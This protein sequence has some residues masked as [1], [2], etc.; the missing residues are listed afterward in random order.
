MAFGLLPTGFAPKTRQDI[1]AELLDDVEQGFGAPVDRSAGSTLTRLLEVYAD[2]LAEGWAAADQLWRAGDPGLA[3]AIALDDLVAAVGVR[4]LFATPSV[5]D[6]LCIGRVGTRLAAGVVVSADGV[7]F[8]SAADA[9]L[10]E[11]L[12]SARLE[13]K[14]VVP[15]TFYG[16]R[17]DGVGSGLTASAGQSAQR[18]ATALASLWTPAFPHLLFEARGDGVDL[19]ARA[20]DVVP[21]VTL[22][23]RPRQRLRVTLAQMSAGLTVTV[24]VWDS[25]GLVVRA[26]E[27][28]DNP[29][30]Y[31]TVIANLCGRLSGAALDARPGPDGRSID[32]V[33]NSVATSWTIGGWPGVSGVDRTPTDLATLTAKTV[34][35]AIVRFESVANGPIPALAGRLCRVETPL[36]GWD[37]VIN[38]DRAELGRDAETDAKLRGRLSRSRYIMASG[39]AGAIVARLRQDVPGLRGAAV[40]ENDGDA[41]DA[42]GRPAHSFE[43]VVD[44]NP[45]PATSLAIARVIEGLRPAGVAAVSTAVPA[46]RVTETWLDAH[47][48]E[49]TLVYSRPT[50]VPVTLEIAL[51]AHPDEVF[52]AGAEAALRDQVYSFGAAHGIGQ[53]V[54]IG[55]M[56]ALL[57]AFPGVGAID[58]L[59]ARRDASS[60]PGNIRIGPLELASF[61]AAD[62]ASVLL[63]PP[64]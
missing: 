2:A 33:A 32:I 46:N 14:E 29:A 10:E 55:R 42:A 50:R 53:D 12:W 1:L 15:D 38:A 34:G 4:R 49:R 22:N 45:D 23:I 64:V 54:V 57:H 52:P 61:D 25:A 24:D 19:W 9:V 17:F 7:R 28:A 47:G 11:R 59:V 63:H 8:L 37:R 20:L 13:I 35:G 60:P 6:A 58:F 31:G 43:V 5:V 51:R 26:T 48:Q 44:A 16:L 62:G 39:V 18:L 36:S 21:Q 30:I 40:V 27:T 41:P 56:L 3:E